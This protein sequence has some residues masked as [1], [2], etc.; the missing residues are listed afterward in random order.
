MLK[1]TVES[2]QPDCIK[3]FHILIA[4]TSD[5]LLILIL[6]IIGQVILQTAYQ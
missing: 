3:K 2:S 1:I 4:M 5:W 6:A